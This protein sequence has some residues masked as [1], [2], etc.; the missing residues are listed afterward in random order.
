[1]KGAFLRECTATRAVTGLEDEALTQQGPH[2]RSAQSNQRL[3]DVFRALNMKQ[4]FESPGMCMIASLSRKDLS[5]CAGRPGY[6]YQLNKKNEGQSK[7]T[8]A[9]NKVH[10][11]EMAKVVHTSRRHILG[12]RDNYA[13]RSFVK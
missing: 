4:K 10:H 7:T 2:A 1:M 6:T 8:V 13:S 9:S 5:G 12:H 3:A 11:Y